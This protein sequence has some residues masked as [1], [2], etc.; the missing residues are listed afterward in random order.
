MEQIS[1]NF[2]AFFP[3][4]ITADSQL[5]EP[6]HATDAT[7]PNQQ[8]EASA[9]VLQTPQNSN[10]ASPREPAKPAI[11]PKVRRP[12]ETIVLAPPP[13]PETPAPA[14]ANSEARKFPSFADALSFLE[15]APDLTPTKRRDYRSALISAAKLLGQPPQGIRLDLQ[16]LS[17]T[18]LALTP[19][20]RGHQVKRRQNIRSGINK[21]AALM[22]LAHPHQPGADGLMPAWLDLKRRLDAEYDRHHL[23]RLARYCSDR[24]IEPEAVTSAVFTAFGRDLAASAII[25]DRTAY[26][27]KVTNQWARLIDRYRELGLQ[28][29]VLPDKKARLTFPATKF[30]ESFRQELD[31]FKAAMTPENL[32]ALHDDLDLPAEQRPFRPSRPLK[33]ST[34]ALR[35]YQLRC[36]AS[37][38]IHAGHDAK[39]LTNLAGLFTPAS[40]VKTV[41]RIL[42]E[43]GAEPRSSFVAGIIEALRHAARFCQ[44]D[45]YVHAELARIKGIVEPANNGVVSKNRERLRAMIEPNTRAIIMMLPQFLLEGAKKCTDPLDAARRVRVAVMIELLTVVAPRLGNLNLLHLE[46]SLRRATNG[47]SRAMYLIVDETEVKNGVPIERLLPAATAELIEIWLEKFRPLLAKPGNPWIFPGKK[48]KPMTKDLLGSWITRAVRDYAKVEVHPHLFRHFC[49]WLHLH[50]H[51]GDYEGVR[52]LLGHKRL[53]TS[54]KSYIAFEQDV[55]A[56]RHDD[57]VLKERQVA[58]RVARQM[59]EGFRPG[60]VTR[61]PKKGAFHAEKS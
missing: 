57:A 34:V 10:A 3:A 22:G 30:M 24:N 23:T 50:Y 19:K 12:R 25:S 37:A 40:R 46:R 56:A 32:G 35:V 44:A 26:L 58:K 8:A 7:S 6:G 29:L 49:A 27:R 48:E 54:I 5:T 53:E 17:D 59:L 38:L 15:T 33:P 14:A 21:V 42:R 51:P 9:P 13:Q 39:E 36:A 20:L 52:R 4:S 43:R 61:G 16:A 11:A 45:A 1:F 31:K 55:A 60:K 47:K 28:A 2:E 18:I 41:V